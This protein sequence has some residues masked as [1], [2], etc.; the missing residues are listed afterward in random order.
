[1][2]QFCV[3]AGVIL[4]ALGLNL[5]FGKKY[6]VGNLAPAMLIPVLYYG[7]TLLVQLAV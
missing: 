4:I 6:R 7:V 2:S 1:M 3:I 5:A